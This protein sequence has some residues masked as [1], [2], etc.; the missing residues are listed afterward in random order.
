MNK[1]KLVISKW[2]DK[3]DKNNKILKWFIVV[4]GVICVIGAVVYIKN[5]IYMTESA[6]SNPTMG[7]ASDIRSI[8]RIDTDK[9][10]RDKLLSKEDKIVVIDAGHGGKD[11]GKIGIHNEIEKDINLSI[12]YI[13]KNK[14]IKSGF[15][16]IMTRTGDEGLDSIYD[17]NKKMSDMRKRTEIINLAGAV[18]MV[19]VH[20]NSYVSEKEHGAQSFYYTT[21]DVSKS[22]A[23]AIQE[24]M[25]ANCDGNNSRMEKANDSYYI[26]KKSVIPSVIVECGFLSNDREARM[27]A[28]A[29]YQYKVA[30]AIKL[31]VIKWANDIIEGK[32]N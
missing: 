19:S 21:S 32:T 30:E 16:V 23:R 14:L 20:Q 31:G 13:L 17:K 11:P 15:S 18:C 22:L 24:S 4:G 5:I 25:K 12:A 28:S 3:N 29:S 2:I 8:S 1:I 26:L 10:I 9:Q 7:E 6:Q 27:L